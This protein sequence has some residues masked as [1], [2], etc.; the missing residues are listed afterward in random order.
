MT[1]LSSLSKSFASIIIAGAAVVVLLAAALLGQTVL[2][3]PAALIGA[4]AIGCAAWFAQRTRVV[5]AGATAVV[6]AAGRG[7]F[8]AR[9]LHISESGDLGTLQHQINDTIDRLD[10]F[11]RESGAAMDAV[12]HN[13]YYRLILPAGLA[14]ALLGASR[15]I[16]DATLAMKATID[17]LD[18]STSRFE[19]AVLGIVES[20]SGASSNMGDTANQL[21]DGASAT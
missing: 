17:G 5:L 14:G 6:R 7:D 1:S 11:V 15:L 12:R 3:L 4:A 2:V 16:N 9:I 19:G 20:V 13:K 10:A 21:T 8:E 18:T